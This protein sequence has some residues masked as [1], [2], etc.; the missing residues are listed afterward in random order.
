MSS[1]SDLN[2]IYEQS[3]R[4]TAHIVNP[5]NIPQ[6]ER[7][8]DQIAAQTRKLSAKSSRTGDGA[9]RA[10]GTG[11]IASGSS[12]VVAGQ[13]DSRTAYLLANKGFDAD[14]VSATLS[15]I[16][17]AATFEPVEGLYDTDIEGY[18]KQE[19]DAIMVNA[20]EESRSQTLKDCDERFERALHRDWEKA[21]KR[22]FEELGQHQQR[23]SH[24]SF[25][26]PGRP[27]IGRQGASTPTSSV[28][29]MAGSQPIAQPSSSM[30]ML[31]RNKNYAQVIEALN[32]SRLEKKPFELIQSFYS[33]AQK[34]D[35]GDVGHQSLMK[36]WK[37]LYFTLIENGSKMFGRKRQIREL[38]FLKAYRA[39]EEGN[40][41]SE[42]AVQFRKMVIAGGKDFLQENHWDY[43]QQVVQQ[44]RVQV[45][46]MPSVNVI[47]NAYIELKYQRY[48]SW[49]P[50]HGLEIIEG[51]AAW[52]HL[53]YLLRSGLKSEALQYAEEFAVRMEGSPDSRFFVYFREYL[54]DRRLSNTLRNELVDTWNSRIRQCLTVDS[55]GRPRGDPFKAALYKIV[56]RCEMNS[57]NIKNAD[58]LPSVEDYIWLQLMLIHED[59]RS[60]DV[61]QDR[62]TLRDMAKTI[63]RFGAAHFS[64]QNRSPH[65]Y[66]LVLML[67]GEY[68]RAVAHIITN[69]SFGVEALHFAVALAYYG[70]LRVPDSPHMVD[71]GYELLS[72]R[73]ADMAAFGSFEI[74]YFQFERMIQQYA[75]QFFKSDPVDALHYL[76]LIC[77]FAKDS[78]DRSVEG[79]IG[80]RANAY[81][82]ATFSHIRELLLD[83][84][85]SGLLIGES[86]QEGLRIRGEI[87]KLGALIRIDQQDELLSEI[88][89]PAAEEADRLGKLS[90][91][92]KLYDFAQEYDMVVGILCKQLG[93]ALAAHRPPSELSDPF[94]SASSLSRNSGGLSFGLGNGLGS[95]GRQAPVAGQSIPT[96]AME[97]LEHYRSL[98]AI[99][100]KISEGKRL[101][102]NLLIRL[103]QFVKELDA[104][105]PEVALN[106]LRSSGL[107]PTDPDMAIITRLAEDFRAYN[108][109]I[110]KCLPQILLMAMHTVAALYRNMRDGRFVDGVKQTRLMELKSNARAILLYA[111]SIQYRIPADTLQRLNRLDAVM[112]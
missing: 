48:G 1:M 100:A 57:K 106:T 24:R 92:V 31:P 4:L 26:S 5:G 102:C 22:I 98:P 89:R 35:R 3:R 90:E 83:S 20:I 6:L 15:M 109:S 103:H 76:V 99:E 2:Q 66:F 97:V 110:A 12:G 58:V 104:G 50:Q 30:Q 74:G 18:L 93:D 38:E 72:I 37:L 86:T 7:G 41:M 42:E 45:G 95:G 39:Q 96:H 108:E 47:I 107:V 67:C 34:L 61:I 32:K 85:I 91:A 43:V 53:Y 62:Y 54:E 84:N 101:T 19:H 56:G 25:K 17:P 80:A 65:V 11:E 9:F 51:S 21:K 33:V 77:I 60:E 14:K 63:L 10:S 71:I 112:N 69:E 55:S 8:L 46:G 40:G 75:S 44:Q 111:S 29:G 36:C 82:Q 88:I 16:D 27:L 23:P 59:L 78:V 81:L 79:S 94:S 13:I 87:E 64:P 105:Q 73:T 70:V 28:G 68:E 52:A 49:Q